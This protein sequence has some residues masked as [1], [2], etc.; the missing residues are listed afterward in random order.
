MRGTA[1]PFLRVYAE[2]SV[3]EVEAELARAMRTQVGNSDEEV[4]EWLRRRDFSKQESEGIINLAKIEEGDA[5]TAWQLVNGGTA[6]ARL[7]PHTETRVA[8]ERRVSRLL[9][10]A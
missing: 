9:H 7:I 10:A 3:S 4:L 2:A 6:L 8:F 1:A 5:R